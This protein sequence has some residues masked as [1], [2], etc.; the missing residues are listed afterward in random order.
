MIEINPS[1]VEEKHSEESIFIH[2]D[3][4]SAENNENSEVEVDIVK[5][6]KSKGISL[7]PI[8]IAKKRIRITDESS[9]LIRQS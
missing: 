8:H 9:P 7:H 3:L 5:P 6:R 1:I 4:N 2:I